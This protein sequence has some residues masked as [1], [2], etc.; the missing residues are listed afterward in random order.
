MS[1]FSFFKTSM[2]KSRKAD[3]HLGCLDGSVFM[4]FNLSKDKRIYL[5][6]ISF[7]GYGCCELGT[8]HK[9]DK[10][11]SKEFVTMIGKELLDQEAIEIFL[12]KIIKMNEEEIWKDA[13][14]E[15]ELI[16]K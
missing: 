4:D 11:G 8:S 9:L 3:Y 14:K 5:K 15:Y 16:E 12:K 2:P 1:K 6:R 7:D 10:E 13:L